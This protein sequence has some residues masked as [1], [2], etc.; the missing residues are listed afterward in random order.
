MV[1]GAWH[2]PVLVPDAFPT[3]TADA[4]RLRGLP[5]VK[6]AATW[7]PWTTGRLAR[8]SGYGAGVTSPGWYAHLF[9]AGE[10]A[11]TVTSSPRGW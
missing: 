10:T 1:C 4:D 11:P 5:K 6:V 2:A 3:K 7:V 8:A 9:A